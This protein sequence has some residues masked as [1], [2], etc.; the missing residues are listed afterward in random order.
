MA[1]TLHNK[2]RPVL[3]AI[4]GSFLVTELVCEVVPVEGQV[5]QPRGADSRFVLK[6]MREIACTKYKYPHAL[7]TLSE[8]DNCFAVLW[9]PPLNR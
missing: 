3:L 8:H 1:T 5:F 9:E 2:L 7:L 4:A 6:I